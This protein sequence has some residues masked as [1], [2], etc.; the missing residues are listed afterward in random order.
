MGRR[1]GWRV[2][3]AAPFARAISRR[4]ILAGSAALTLLAACGD[5]SSN[6]DSSAGRMSLEPD[7]GGRVLI[8]NFA[9]GDNYLIS[10]T[11]QRMPFL[12][13]VGGAP[14][15]DAPPTLIMQLSQDGQDVGPPIEVP[16][17]TDGVPLPYFPLRTT[18]ERPGLYTVTTALDGE[19][20]T[21]TMQV[22]EPDAVSLVQPGRPM[23][24][25]DTPTIDDHRGV[26]P[27]CTADPPCPLH[28]QT[29]A[30]ALGSGRPIAILVGT[31]AYCQT[32]LCGPVLDLL[33][34]AIRDRP[35]IRFVHAE[36]YRDAAA[37]G[38]VATAQTAPI[39]DTFGLTFEPSLFVADA[40]GLVRAR[41]DNVYDRVE[42]REALALVG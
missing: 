2:V 10:G 17:H 37:T 22:S 18:F 34:E 32:G 4:S 29:L 14:T 26:E 27:I 35:Q 15:T 30:A 39:I 12:V 21:Q 6:D 40:T 19:P 7:S 31:P 41:L 25:A 8:A 13:G 33:V 42:L 24:S 1:I 3:P 38:N 28:A 11:P 23:P 9:Y 16:A 20:V 36:V 5:G